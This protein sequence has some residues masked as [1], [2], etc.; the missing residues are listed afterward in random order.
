MSFSL[1]GLTNRTGSISISGPT[2]IA[3]VVP[4]K[5][6]RQPQSLATFSQT[7][8]E[9]LYLGHFEWSQ[10]QTAI[11]LRARRLKCG[12]TFSATSFIDAR[13]FFG[14]IPGSARPSAK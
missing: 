13:I 3:A 1:P 6:I 4:P 11:R 10:T 8:S 7:G 12:I 5:C 14:S 2:S 9:Q